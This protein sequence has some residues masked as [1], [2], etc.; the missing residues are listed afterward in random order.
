[1]ELVVAKFGGSSVADGRQLRKVRDIVSGDP[2]RKIIVVSAPGK[3]GP[4]DAKL[5]D[6]LYLCHDMAAIG[7]DFS[8]P[9][10][11]IRQR[12]AA[13]ITD[14]T[15][16][17]DL[18]KDIDRF[19]DQLLAGCSRDYAASRGEYFSARLVATYLGARF[20]DPAEGIVL[21][22]DG[23]VAPESYQLLGSL[24]TDRGARYV[25]AG[26]YG[27]DRKGQVKTFSRGGS[28]ISGAI[29]ARAAGAVLYENWTDTPG[30]L[31]ADPRI[32]A[33]P[34]PI[35]EISFREIREM[36]YM[37]ASVFHDEAI[38]PLR[39]AG[40]PIRIKNTNQPAATGTLITPRLS[41][42]A[43]TGTEIA[44]IAGRKDFAMLSLEKTLMNREVG[45]VQRLLGILSEY[46]ISFEHC[47][48]SIDSVSVIVDKP[49]LT[50]QLE[51]VVEQIHRRLTPDNLTITDDLALVAVVG[52]GMIETIGIAGKIFTALGQ[53]KVNVRIINQGASEINIII[54]VAAGD[55]EKAVQALYAAFVER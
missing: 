10:S 29:A 4:D 51:A 40:I 17:A 12:F 30:I 9:F 31:M 25:M 7:T 3:R 5:T 15:L 32:I 23:R 42:A 27:R 45:Y 8:A 1:M 11:L 28:D 49:A 26:F 38:L 52:E 50:G 34:L 47:P 48:S 37:G 2:R 19:A 14:L 13:I 54:G 24:F 22:A 44:G 43:I 21:A 55:Y 53:A 16:P 41:E 39:E 6:L 18:L 33:D 36:A 20:I 46:R 35:T